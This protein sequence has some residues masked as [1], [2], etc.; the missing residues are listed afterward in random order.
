MHELVPVPINDMYL[1]LTSERAPARVVEAV[2]DTHLIWAGLGR[3][4]KVNALTVVV[5]P[6][7]MAHEHRIGADAQRRVVC[8]REVIRVDDD[9]V[10][11]MAY[12]KA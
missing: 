1:I 6:V 2:D 5:P 8:I 11:V 7:L 9:A 4:G 10:A 3:A 12:L